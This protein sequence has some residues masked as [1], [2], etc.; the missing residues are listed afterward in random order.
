MTIARRRCKA[1]IELHPPLIS[2]K[3]ESRLKCQGCVRSR[4][5][6][7]GQLF[8]AADIDQAF[9]AEFG[10][11]PARHLVV[12]ARST[13]LRYFLGIDLGQRQDHSA[14]AVLERHTQ[15]TGERDPVTYTPHQVT[16]LVL[17]HIERFPLNMP[18]TSLV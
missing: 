14:I 5:D 10:P 16:T 18:Y 17:R 13:E 4:S 7:D 8:P 11:I 2:V 9:T 6:A 1:K 15:L 3:Q 12:T